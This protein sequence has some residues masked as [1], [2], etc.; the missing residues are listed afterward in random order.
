MD[1]SDRFVD[2]PK[3]PQKAMLFG[4]LNSESKAFPR[5]WIKGTLD[6]AGSKSILVRKVIPILNVGKGNY[7]WIQDGASIHIANAILKSQGGGMY[8]HRGQHF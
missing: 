3:F 8:R 2:W 6:A 7:T 4:V 1:T 5:V